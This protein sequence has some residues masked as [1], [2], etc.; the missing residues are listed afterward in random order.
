[1]TANNNGNDGNNNQFDPFG[2]PMSS[3]NSKKKEMTGDFGFDA[4]FANFDA[5]N[6]NGTGNG[7][8]GSFT[9]LD[10]W[11]GSLDKKNNN[12]VKKH[13]KK[14]E[15]AK[16]SKFNTDYSDNFDQ[17]LEQVLKRSMMEQ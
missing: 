6:N 4:D 16:V 3:N 12:A 14:V 13:N 17:D 8:N 15:V 2:A 7:T 11:G 5:F 9:K 10:A 1:M